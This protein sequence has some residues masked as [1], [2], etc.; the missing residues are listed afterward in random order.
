MG[1]STSYSDQAAR[2]FT[3]ASSTY[4]S[5][6]ANGN[7]TPTTAPVYQTHCALYPQGP[8]TDPYYNLFGTPADLPGL[9]NGDSTK[10]QGSQCAAHETRS[11]VEPDVD[12]SYTPLDWLTVYGGYDV[13]YRSPALGGGGGQFQSVNPEFYTLAKGAYSQVGAKVHLTNAPVLHNFIAGANYFHLDYTNQEIDFETAAGV[14]ESGGGNSTNH[15]VDAFFDDDPAG[16]IHIMVNLAAEAARYTT[17]IEGGPSLAECAAQQLSCFSY[18]NLPVSYVPNVTFNAAV[19]YGIRHHN[20]VILEPRFWIQTTGTQ[21][22]SSNLTAAPT[23]QT[24]PSYTTA[25]LAFN[26]PIVFHKQSFNLRVDMLNLANKEYN[27]WE[28]ISSGGYFRRADPHPPPN[29][30]TS[31]PT[32]VPHAPSTAR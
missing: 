29:P 14:E 30:D 1:F 13:T 6:D 28:Y 24:M 21:H 27:E 17:Y 4:Y 16:N 20:R 9:P 10:D 8:G 25:N 3:F 18:N 15:G 19:Y 12:A 23:T 26:A 32:P 2:D 5:Q 22:L 11:A 7:I 31:T